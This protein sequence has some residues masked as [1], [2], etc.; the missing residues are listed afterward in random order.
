MKQAGLTFAIT[1]ALALCTRVGGAQDASRLLGGTDDDATAHFG[2]PSGSS[3]DRLEFQPC[4]EAANRPQWK[5]SLERARVLSITR[6]GCEY[7]VLDFDAARNEARQFLPADAV[8]GVRRAADSGWTVLE[9][10]SVSLGSRLP[11]EAFVGC[12]GAV[13]S[14]GAFAF[15]FSVA[16]RSWVLSLKTCF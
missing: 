13:N 8:T 11:P 1:L 14:P 15:A 2:N 5:V 6:K 16:E 4:P 3:D 12:G 9:F 7:R 10:T